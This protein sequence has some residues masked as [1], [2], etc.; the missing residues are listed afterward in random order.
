MLMEFSG[1]NEES[2]EKREGDLEGDGGRRGEVG[3]T[4]DG[5]H[6]SIEYVRRRRVMQQIQEVGDEFLKEN[7]EIEVVDVSVASTADEQR[8]QER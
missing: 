1:K 4:M 2:C 3:G 7:H 5:M 6:F 8:K